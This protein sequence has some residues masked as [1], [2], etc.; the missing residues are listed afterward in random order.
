[1]QS[2]S[3]VGTAIPSFR[4]EDNVPRASLTEKQGA[5]TGLRYIYYLSDSHTG[6]AWHPTLKFG[7]YRG[8]DNRCCKLGWMHAYRVFKE[9]SKSERLFRAP[10]PAF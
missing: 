1:M 10:L 3:V 5:Q 6:K 9:S 4:K 7:F 2:V 8:P